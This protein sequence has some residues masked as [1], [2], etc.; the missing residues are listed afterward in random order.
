MARSNRKDVNDVSGWVGWVYFAGFML[1]LVG[2]FNAIAGLVGLFKNEVYVA[3][4]AN[5]WLLDYT[6]WG[7]AHLLLGIFLLVAGA[8]IMSGKLWGRVVGVI[9]TGLS[10]IANF[11]FVPVYPFWAILMVVISI[12]VLYALIVHGDEANDLLE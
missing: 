6:T 9:V 5:L 8:A 7:W 12:L 1:T 10:L 4:Q 11:G 3:G 2:V